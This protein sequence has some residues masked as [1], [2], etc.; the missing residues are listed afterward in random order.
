MA[1]V[2]DCGCDFELFS[3]ASAICALRRMWD[4]VRI[5]GSDLAGWFGFIE[6]GQDRK[7]HWLGVLEELG[8]LHVLLVFPINTGHDGLKGDS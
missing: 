2:R 1:P 6:V 5:V 8:E 7:R 4:S 3:A